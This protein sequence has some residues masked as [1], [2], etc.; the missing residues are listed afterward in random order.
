MWKNSEQKFRVY[1]SIF[2]VC[3]TKFRDKSIF[4][5]LWVKK[6]KNY[7]MQTLILLPNFIF[8]A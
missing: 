7:L 5:V 3:L 6:Q 1:I 8:F 4:L 2:Y